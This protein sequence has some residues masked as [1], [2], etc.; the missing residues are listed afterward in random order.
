ML[1]KNELSQQLTDEHGLK[2]MRKT[3]RGN[4]WEKNAAHRR[5]L[6]THIYH[7]PPPPPYSISHWPPSFTPDL[8]IATVALA[9]AKYKNRSSV[10]GTHQGILGCPRFGVEV[11]EGNRAEAGVLLCGTSLFSASPANTLV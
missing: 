6:L 3:D 4:S 11:E 5:K 7:V 10:Q 2:D 8:F 9:Q 1:G